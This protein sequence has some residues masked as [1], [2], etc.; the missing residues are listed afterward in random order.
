MCVIKPITFQY[1]FPPDM[2]IF[3]SC[4]CCETT[5]CVRTGSGLGELGVVSL[6][7]CIVCWRRSDAVVKLISPRGPTAAAATFWIPIRHRIQLGMLM[8]GLQS[9]PK[10]PM[11]L[12]SLV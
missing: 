6:F 4:C 2:Y 7:H 1:I 10:R 11:R 12:A 9:A 8:I 5:L 3:F